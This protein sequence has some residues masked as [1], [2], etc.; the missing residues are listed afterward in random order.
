MRRIVDGFVLCVA[1][2]LYSSSG[3]AA[4]TFTPYTPEQVPQNV[5]DLWKDYDTRI[6]AYYS[7]PD[8]GGKSHGF[9][10]LRGATLCGRSVVGCGTARQRL[11]LL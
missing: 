11:R 1:V 8:G 10:S 9:G 7:F 3:T 5:T 4:E 2:A 6:A